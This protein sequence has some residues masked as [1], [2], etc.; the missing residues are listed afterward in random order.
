MQSLGKALSAE[1]NLLFLEEKRIKSE[2]KVRFH[3]EQMQ[4]LLFQLS[5]EQA[6]LENRIA[7]LVRTGICLS[8]CCYS[9]KQINKTQLSLNVTQTNV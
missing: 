8:D 9:P 6:T 2:R 3:L 7:A 1:K 4:R 5:S